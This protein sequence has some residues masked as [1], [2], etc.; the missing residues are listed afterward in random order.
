[1]PE[2]PLDQVH[3][4]ALA[5]EVGSVAVPQAVGVNRDVVELLSSPGWHPYDAQRV[6]R[7]VETSAQ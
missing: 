7:D 4:N 3:R 5:Y 1:M 2:L 6:A